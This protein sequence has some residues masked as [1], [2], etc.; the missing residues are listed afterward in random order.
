MPTVKQCPSGN[1]SPV[2]IVHDKVFLHR[3]EGATAEGATAWLCQRASDASTHLISNADGSVVYQLVPLRFKAWAQVAYNG[4]GVSIEYPG[5]T[6]QGVPDATM[7]VMGLHTAWILR[8]Y[9][10][11]CQHAKGGQGRGYTMHHDLGP[12][13]GN[14]TDVCGVEDATWK[15]IE[16]YIKQS[17][18]AFG[19]GPL[20]PFALHGLPAPHTVS[21]PPNV[22]PEVSHGGAARNE[23][24]DVVAHPTDST[25]PHGSVADLQ[26]RLNKA[27][28]K[29]PLVVDGL[30]GTLT[31]DAL[32][33]FQGSHGLYI[34]GL[35]GPITWAALDEETA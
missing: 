2:P 23:P 3:T 8:T 24:G 33:K 29:P 1:Y 15:Q 32:A 31:R 28:A 12:A 10:I 26:F 5:F 13:G 16:A 6:A 4:Q 20:P 27:G 25:Y 14:H 35:I 21:L 11:P 17:Y 22:P 9:G 19:D 18:D 7:R 34:D 30:A